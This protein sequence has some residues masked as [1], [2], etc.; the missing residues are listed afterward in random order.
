MLAALLGGAADVATTQYNLAQGGYEQN[1]MLPQG[2]LANGLALGGSYVANA[3]LSKYLNDHGHSTMA[4]LIGY[5]GGVDG[6]VAAIHNILPNIG[7]K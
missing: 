7:R 2:R 4:K 1:P 5:G 3:L 6:G